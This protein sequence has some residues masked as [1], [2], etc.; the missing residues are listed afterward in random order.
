MILSDKP[1]L[2]LWPEDCQQSVISTH[3]KVSMGQ[4]TV[5]EYYIQHQEIGSRKIFPG[6]EMLNAKQ[7]PQYQ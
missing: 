3:C 5:Q 7:C 2:T 4:R 1:T 6:L